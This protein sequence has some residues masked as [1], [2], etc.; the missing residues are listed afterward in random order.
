MLNLWSEIQKNVLSIIR[1]SFIFNILFDSYFALF[2]A[3]VDGATF[4]ESDINELKSNLK[5]TQRVGKNICD[6]Y[7]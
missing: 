6:T 7:I 2:I 5:A 3:R 1:G 4:T